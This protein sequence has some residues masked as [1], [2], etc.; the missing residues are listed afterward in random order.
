MSCLLFCSNAIAQRDTTKRQTI[1]ITSSY[2]PVLRN[3][4]K[5]NLS[6]SPL[7]ADTSRPRLSYDIPPQN[8]FFAY[9][10]VSLKPL[11]LMQDTGLQLGVR[12][13]VKAGFGNYSTPYIAAAISMGDGKKS[14]VNAYG[15]YISSKGKIINQDFSELQ[16]KGTGSLFTPKNEAY[17]SVGINARQYYQYGYNHLLNTFSKETV[18]R[19]YQ[20]LSVAAGLRNI[21]VNDLN[22]NYDP[23]AVVHFF[24]RENKISESTL[25]I[26]TP[27]EKKIGESVSFK[28]AAKADITKLTNKT[29][30]VSSTISNNL[31]QGA[32]E[33]VYYSDRFTFHGGVTPSWDN[34]VLSV[35]P[36][37]YG[38]AQLQHKVL[39]I[40]AGWVGRFIKNSF[41][42][43]S[44]INPY[45]ADPSFLLNTKEVQ[46]YGGI[47][48]TVGKHLSFNAK[49][50]YVTYNNMP[51]FVNDF[52]EGN[53][54]LIRNER[55]M[56]ALQLHGDVSVVSQDKFTFTAA[57]DANTYTGLKDNAK[58][59]H[60][61]PLQLTGSFRWNAFKQV[62]V[63]ADL[64]TFSGAPALLKNN[65]EK[66]LNGTDLSAGAEFKITKK[67]SAWLDFNN[68][69]DNKY[70]RF[71]NYP[72]YGLNIIGGIIAH[73]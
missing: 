24:S 30:S 28:V 36:N 67:F 72:V 71:N 56:N 73:F 52:N 8:L 66:K 22:I 69:F 6:A 39:M 27:V 42:S 12:N 38:E 10:P 54:F 1:D 58:A 59:W 23:N 32:P 25:I 65:T 29:T 62:L 37:V 31:F 46:Y 2:K 13:Y 7:A 33:L 21:A 34:G 53:S 35:L 14:L 51:L 20:D 43:L 44:T 63:K 61:I 55:K 60:L 57:L 9:Q 49:A 11:G 64:F 18:R 26:E 47:K 70:Q 40:Q 4:V 15:N 45:M 5:I 41:R 16:L 17:G 3:A 50:A 68:I 19:K 48:A